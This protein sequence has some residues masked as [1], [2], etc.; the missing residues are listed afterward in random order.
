MLENIKEKNLVFEKSTTKQLS[1]FSD[2]LSEL[3]PRPP[4]S[5]VPTYG[6]TSCYKLSESYDNAYLIKIMFPYMFPYI[7][8]L[9]HLNILAETTVLWYWF[10]NLIIN[11]C[12]IGSIFFCGKSSTLHVISKST[13]I[14]SNQI[15]NVIIFSFSSNPV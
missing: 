7:V 11:K 9:N 13:I 12:C 6:R 4:N 15:P 3:N 5:P 10:F 14:L 2:G 1:N 8:I